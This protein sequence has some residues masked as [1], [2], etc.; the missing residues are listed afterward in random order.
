MK[1]KLLRLS[2]KTPNIIGLILAIA[3]IASNFAFVPMAF[4][5]D[6]NPPAPAEGVVVDQPVLTEDKDR[7]SE[8]DPINPSEMPP[9]NDGSGDP[10]VTEEV[11]PVVTE[12][13]EPPKEDP[14]PEP[15]KE[16][17]GCM[18]E[19]AVNFN[20]TA[21]VDN[22]SC[23]YPPVEPV[24]IP[25]C[26]DETAVNFNPTATVDNGSCEYPPV[27]P[28]EIP[29]CMD[30]TAVNFN[31]TAT[32]DNGSCEYPPVE[33]VEIPG[34][35]DET[36]VNFNPTATVDNRSC[37]PVTPDWHGDVTE[38]PTC[39]GWE[40]KVNTVWNG[41]EGVITESSNLVGTWAD[42]Q[43]SADWSVT[44]TWYDGEGNVIDTW[45]ASGTIY[46]PDC[47]PPPPPAP[48]C[49]VNTTVVNEDE[50]QISTNVSWDGGNEDWH[51]LT[52]GDGTDVGFQ[53]ASGNE[54]R[55][56]QFSDY[57][58]YV[59]EFT[60]TG[61]GGTTSCS[62]EVTFEEPPPP[63]PAP[64]C[65]VNTTVVN[66]D[67]K[68]IST[69]VSWDGGNEDWHILTW[70][71][72]TDV[73]FQ[74]ASGNETREH[75]FS[76]Y[77][78]YVQE[79]TVTGPGGTTSCSD[80][81][82]FE[83]PPP[84]P[85]PTCSLEVSTTD[86]LYEAVAS[87]SYGNAYEDGTTLYWG[88]NGEQVSFAGTDGTFEETHVYPEAG[89]YRLR[90][91]VHGPGGKVTCKAKVTFEPPPPPP[92][93]TCS[94]EVST[95]DN[96][97]EAVASGSYGNAYEDGTTLY[98]GHNGEQVSFAGTDG[99][100]EETHVYPEAGTY[101]LRLVVHGPGGK[102]TC[103]AKVT[104]EPPPP[105]PAPT[106][107]LSTE[108]T[109]QEERR[110]NANASWENGEGWQILEWGDETEVGFEG[111]SGTEMREHQY[112]SAGTYDLTFTV[113]GPGGS[114]TCN[115]SVTFEPP[116]PPP[117]PTCSLSTEITSQEERRINANA[118][119]ENGEG[120]QILEWGD[121]TEVGF[122]GMSGTE[123]REHQYTSAGTYDLTFTVTGPG[124]SVTC[125]DSVTF[126]EP[127]TTT[128][129]PPEVIAQVAQ[130]LPEEH[131][132][133][134]QGMTISYILDEIA[135]GTFTHEPQVDVKIDLDG[136]STD[137]VI[138][139]T[140]DGC[141]W[142]FSVETEDQSD[143]YSM[144]VFGGT[145]HQLTDTADV[146]EL[147]PF[148]STD[149]HVYFTAER[150]G[151]YT[152]E[153]IKLD[154]SERELMASDCQKPVVS[155]DGLVMVC[156][157]IVNTA[158][159]QK[160]EVGA[161]A[162]EADALGVE[163]ATTSI[164]WYPDQE[165]WVMQQAGQFVSKP[166]L[167]SGD[168]KIFS[169]DAESLA[170]RPGGGYVV[171]LI[172]GNLNVAEL[173]NEGLP[174]ELR[175]LEGLNQDSL[176]GVKPG[177]WSPDRLTPTSQELA[178]P[179]TGQPIDA[180][181]NSSTLSDAQAAACADYSGVSVVDCLVQADMDASFSARADLAV[182]L[183]IVASAAD[184]IGSMAQNIALLTALQ[185]GASQ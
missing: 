40:V 107:S 70:G 82:T 33:P 76:D 182:N 133:W 158:S 55:E 99:T 174:T 19:T 108:I 49:S 14:T 43:Q 88:H 138:S 185:G 62:D 13:V 111:M 141:Q 161:T 15:P 170:F 121:E 130:C 67:E 137:P 69:N 162:L 98:W 105:P 79:F 39:E 57:G 71:D 149:N 4:A 103:K 48:T 97:Y 37:V 56:H 81:V 10:V 2:R 36:A 91:V 129:A 84:P 175:V 120:W 181:S 61:P 183:G 23:E 145:P 101:R 65:S 60:V 11:G 123:M 21:T 132:F 32:V 180:S 30:E 17:P 164:T 122:E 150:D 83:P 163:G 166:Y 104:F 27:E 115:D 93:P 74:G 22:G 50:K 24:E 6:N 7:G 155:P 51:I 86:N 146:N 54:T 90:L 160:A 28:V 44:V 156:E 171:M 116:P 102:V 177:W 154:G 31:P 29:G 147:H 52:W 109:S 119:W 168:D 110:I 42:G 68:Q 9:V 159:I 126:E 1:S 134:K 118:S 12:I 85:A 47:P 45:S 143:L 18:D 184:Y 153:R 78:T 112:T 59:Q 96:L 95:T 157:T 136:K 125:N 38:C 46:K 127:P 63:P 179:L 41:Q 178:A 131:I 114:V 66:E 165:A 128:Q 75:Q 167:Q 172:E 176:V 26:M 64:T 169:T 53:G 106:C 92:A 3:M 113:T 73:G 72:G 94:L 135:D 34:C 142:D 173:D 58:T 5:Q 87:G 25:G 8:P 117:A 35:M 16:I 148:T 139:I 151:K 100:F 140:K 20:P 89:T 152:V 77:G 80:E 144:P 124:G